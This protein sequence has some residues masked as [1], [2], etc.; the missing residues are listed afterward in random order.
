VL[1]QE[2]RNMLPYMIKGNWL[3]NYGTL[4]GIGQALSGLARRTRYES[5]MEQSVIELE[6]FYSEFKKEFQLFF[7][8][9]R[10]HAEEFLKAES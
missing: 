7:P 1:P 9:L 4:E 8:E 10:L 2:V 6:E 3:V 5:K